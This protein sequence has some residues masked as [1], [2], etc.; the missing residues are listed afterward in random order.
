MP[1][2]LERYSNKVSS[3]L[4][5]TPRVPSHR[6]ENPSLHQRPLKQMREQIRGERVFH[7][8]RSNPVQLA[9]GTLQRPSR[10]LCLGKRFCSATRSSEARNQLRIRCKPHVDTKLT[11]PLLNHNNHGSV[12]L[13]KG[14]KLNGET[15]MDTNGLEN[16]HV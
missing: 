10:M 2:K 6:R 16:L 7:L 9:S 5:R 12:A 13:T 4:R 1:R 15:R 3:F 14:T 8:M 11:T